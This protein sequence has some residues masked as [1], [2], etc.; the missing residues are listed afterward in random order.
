M[1]YTHRILT[2]EQK[3]QFEQEGYIIV[4]GLF[5]EEQLSE[6]ERTF[7]DISND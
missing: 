2:E 7:D 1:V 5:T 4:K 6:I 3:R